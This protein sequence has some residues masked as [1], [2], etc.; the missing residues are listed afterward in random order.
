M[1]DHV[2]VK[3]YKVLND[4]EGCKV[5]NRIIAPLYHLNGYDYKKKKWNVLYDDDTIYG[6]FWPRINKKSYGGNYFHIRE[7]YIKKHPLD[8]KPL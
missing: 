8:F 4:I 2:E 6:C 5:K 7:S 1:K 3:E